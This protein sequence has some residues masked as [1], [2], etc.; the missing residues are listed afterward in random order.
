MKRLIDAFLAFLLILITSP[1]W[2]LASFIIIFSDPGPIFYKQRRVG[3]NE[4]EFDI[5]KFRT[6]YKYKKSDS[7]TTSKAD[8]RIIIGGG[9]LRKYKIDELPQLINVVF[10]TMSLVGPRPTVK[11]DLEKMSFEQR[12]RF[13][14]TPGLTGLAQISGN[15]SLLWRDRITYDLDYIERKTFILDLSIMFKTL[16]QVLSGK[17][18]THPSGESEWE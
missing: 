1:L 2:I 11:D 9:F 16:L 4:N 15:T 18:D 6:M 5:F 13:E 3:L 12:K 17:A 10:G 14:V 7:A 8:A